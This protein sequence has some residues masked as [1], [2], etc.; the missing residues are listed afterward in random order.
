LVAAEIS[1]FDLQTLE[2]E[3]LEIASEH[4]ILTFSR[5]KLSEFQMDAAGSLAAFEN[6]Y[7]SHLT[8]A[9]AAPYAGQPIR[10]FPDADTRELGAWAWM[11]SGNPI[12]LDPLAA[13]GEGF[14][15]SNL[16]QSQNRENSVWGFVHE[17]GHDFTFTNGGRYLIGPGPTEAWANIFTLYTLANLGYPE[18]DQDERCSDLG[19]FFQQG[20]YQTFKNDTWLPLCMFFELKEVYGWQLFRDFFRYYNFLDQQTAP[21]KFADDYIRWAWLNAEFSRL[22]GGD[23]SPVFRKYH[24]PLIAL[25]S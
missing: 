2:A 21:V 18:A 19:E 1:S 12:R 25:S 6:F 8:L 9:G 22:A 4:V 24:V 17:M 15:R 7:Q 13:Y 20:D 10:Y 23:V 16:L 3:E 11:L 5:A 14:D